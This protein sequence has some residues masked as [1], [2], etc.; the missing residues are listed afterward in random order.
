MTF[1]IAEAGNNFEGSMKLAYELIC[2]AKKSG[3]DAVKFQAGKAC[4][5]ARTQDQVEFYK[6]YEM[7]LDDYMDMIKYGTEIGMPVFFS[8]WSKEYMSLN[9]FTKYRKIAARQFDLETVTKYDNENT[10]ISIPN[11]F[12]EYQ[13]LKLEKAIPLHCI[14]EYPN[15]EPQ[16][17][18]IDIL[19]AAYGKAG[20]SDHTIGIDN[21]IKAVKYFGACVIEKHF[22]LD[23]RIKGIRDH[24]LSAD[25]K[26][27]KI[28]CEAVK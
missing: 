16:L 28:L 13:K 11:T 25:P 7:K 26:D 2:E 17:W 3:A 6:K 20:Y 18:T 22:T 15:F 21:A 5:F 27:L 19:R 24:I 1:V 10:F 23:K 9:K 8:I 4:D 12:Y 14:S